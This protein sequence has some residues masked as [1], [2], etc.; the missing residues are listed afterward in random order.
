MPARSDPQEPNPEAARLVTSFAPSSQEDPVQPPI[1]EVE[2]SHPSARS[3]IA[4]VLAALVLTVTLG[5]WLNADAQRRAPA[6]PTH[7]SAPSDVSP[8]RNA[9][10]PHLPYFLDLRA[11]AAI[12]V[13][14][15]IAGG[16][17]YAASPE[18]TRVA[19]VGTGDDGTPQIFT[20][21]IGGTG[22]RQV[23]HDPTGAASPAWSP[24][25]TMIAYLGH[26]HYLAV[27]DLATGE[28]RG[29][30]RPLE[31]GF[32][33]TPDGSSLVFT[34]GSSIKPVLRT[35]PVT[36]GKSTLLIGPR[37]GLND[38][39]DGSLSPDGSLVTFIGSGTAAPEDPSHCGPCRFVANADGTERRVIPNCNWNPAGAWS[40][41]GSRIV[42]AKD[43]NRIIV[44]DIATGD[45]SPV[46]GGRAA[47]W[48]DR[49][50]LLVES[51]PPPVPS[52]G[53]SVDRP[54]TDRLLRTVAGVRFSF[55]TPSEGWVPGPIEKTDGGGFRNGRLL[56]SKSI[57]G[58]QGA[59][60]VVFW[61]SMS[62]GTH[63]RPCGQWWGS[64]VGTVADWAANA[65]INPGTEL[66][67]GPSG[68]TVGGYPAQQVVLKVRKDNAC[69]PGFFYRWWGDPWGPSWMETDVGDTIRVWIV[70]VNGTRLF[71]EAETTTQADADLKKEIRQIVGSIR[72]G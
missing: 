11:G 22:V 49:H 62:D 26:E 35:V 20:A 55:R 47:I 46:G 50:T 51:S 23:T 56:V 39:R 69:D 9:Q 57:V 10:S 12:P 66:L 28:S 17:D 36:G 6:T 67:T 59:E 5:T 27:L 15:N 45:A 44:V 61:T 8:V 63:A 30:T 4:F 71:I 54:S 1:D 7:A 40:P 16:H 3:T 29:I 24:D 48:L 34:G 18:G 58:P 31:S 13:P 2:P 52:G 19:W 14:E 38:A 32:Q 37:D 64:P 53:G 72:F 70:D 41:D 68:V 25:S 33:F 65:S 43:G 60:A 42:C 21:G